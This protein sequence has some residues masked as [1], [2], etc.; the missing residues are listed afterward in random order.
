LDEAEDRYE[1]RWM[2]KENRI[3]RKKYIKAERLR[4]NDIVRRARK[5]DPRMIAEEK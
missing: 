3:I 1:K 2:E 5:F 4:L